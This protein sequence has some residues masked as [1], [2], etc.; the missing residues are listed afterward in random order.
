MCRAGA[1]WGRTVPA[2]QSLQPEQDATSWVHLAVSLS[3]SG[4]DRVQAS[5]AT[6][7]NIG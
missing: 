3:Q 2:S 6:S 4:G 1:R 7:E 5:G